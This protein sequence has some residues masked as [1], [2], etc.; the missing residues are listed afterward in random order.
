M[1][2]K[3][4]AK[5]VVIERKAAEEKTKSGIIIAEVAKKKPSEGIVITVGKDVTEVKVKDKVIFAVYGGME[6]TLPDGKEVVV[7]DEKDIIAI[8]D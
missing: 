3:V 6:V 2:I 1:K 7:M 8:I 4:L 5:N